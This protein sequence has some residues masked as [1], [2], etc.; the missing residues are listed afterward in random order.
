MLGGEKNVAMVSLGMVSLGMV[1]LA[2]ARVATTFHVVT[3]A[4]GKRH[5]TRNVVAKHQSKT[6]FPHLY[7]T[8]VLTE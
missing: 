7:S 4:V 2:T 8:D 3:S 5:I 1:G 6:E